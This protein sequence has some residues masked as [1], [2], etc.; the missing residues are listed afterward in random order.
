M[1]AS[2]PSCSPSRPRSPTRTARRSSSGCLKGAGP[3]RCSWR[4]T[5]CCRA[6][7]R[8]GRRRW[9]STRGTT[10]RPVSLVLVGESWLEREGEGGFDDDEESNAGCSLF[11]VFFFPCFVRGDFCYLH[12]FVFVPLAFCVRRRHWRRRGEREREREREKAASE[13][14]NET[15][16]PPTPP[17]P[18]PSFLSF[19][20]LSSKSRASRSPASASGSGS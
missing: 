17:P 6:S 9:W 3:R 1:P 5:P 10:R 12:T 15:Q 19:F 4:G 7:R 14:R 11:C 2:T 18:P 13:K 16:A 20:F 8:G